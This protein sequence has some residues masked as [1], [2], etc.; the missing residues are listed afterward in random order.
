[1]LELPAKWAFDLF[2]GEAYDKAPIG[3]SGKL[4]DYLIWKRGTP[5]RVVL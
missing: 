5:R 3:R 2:G 1:M 4:A